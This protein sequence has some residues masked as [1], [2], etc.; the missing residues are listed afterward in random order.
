[1]VK[2]PARGRY[3]RLPG[4]SYEI[5]RALD[6]CSDVGAIRSR[7]AAETGRDI[8][9]ASLERYIDQLRSLGL[10]ESP[11]GEPPEQ[12]RRRVRGS[13]LYLRFPAF[14]PDP[15]LAFLARHLG[16]C[17][18]RPFVVA[19]LLSISVGLVVALSH[20]T[21]MWHEATALF[22]P[23]RL[24]LIWVATL[25]VTAGHEFAHGVTCRRSGGQVHEMGFLLIYLQPAFYCNV[26]DAWLFP[27]RAKRL[28]VTAAGAFFELT[29]WSLATLCWAGTEGG[30]ALHVAALAVALTSGIKSLFN[31]NPLIKLDGYY[32]LGDLLEVPN[33]RAEAFRSLRR[34]WPGRRDPS[35]HSGARR[36]VLPAYAALAAVYSVW[37]L[38]IITLGLGRWL[39]HR[40]A[41]PGW[42]AA[43]ALTFATLTPRLKA[44]RPSTPASPEGTPAKR[45]RRGFGLLLLLAA[46]LAGLSL[47]GG[48][49][50]DLVV[51]GPF[52]ISSS[53]N[54]D[55]TAPVDGTLDSVYATEGQRVAAG[56]PVARIS[57]RDLRAERDGLVYQAEAQNAR[58]E[59]LAT[60]PR[61]QEVAAAK[62][63]VGSA[64]A[65]ARFSLQQLE[66]DRVL[67][68]RDV[69]PSAQ[70]EDA[71]RSHAVDVSAL[72]E[73]RAGLALV[74]SGSRPEEIEA[75][76]ADLAALEARIQFLD[77]QLDRLVMR[78][79]CTGVIAT[80]HLESRVG[81]FVHQGQPIA[82]VVETAAARADV[83]VPEKEIADVVTGQRV[84]LMSRSRPGRVF[85]GRVIAIAPEPD[86]TGSS[87]DRTFRVTTALDGSGDRLAP[88]TTGMARIHGA[89]SSLWVIARH[90]LLHY[91]NLESM[92]WS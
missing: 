37:I 83:M 84:R 70:L 40:Y 39:V 29:V 72:Q 1:V 45:P 46:G 53:A 49:P 65:A 25:A 92:P 61:P 62:A 76:R 87:V 71:E 88:G 33:L 54:M 24:A 47:L 10:L 3:F 58:M 69:I 59:Q 44:V 63:K 90:R 23:D 9:P 77:G 50:A 13:I 4:P 7:L 67:Y 64:E 35:S 17:F 78:S 41:G 42:V 19:C 81:A 85:S 86:S 38:S 34:L 60:G 11:D 15:L 12:G 66:R 68:Q 20:L 51:S 52:R 14:D 73:A 89:R 21:A 79:P 6:G 26:S 22:R 80:P 91:L 43:G 32:L 16:F 2:D 27:E 56:Q 8:D 5:A 31:M 30:G 28:W 36:W 55:L 57:D 74:R 18:T 82:R 48:L 75:A